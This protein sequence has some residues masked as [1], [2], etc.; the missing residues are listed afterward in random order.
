MK[1]TL[2]R[3]NSLQQRIRKILYFTILSGVVIY[4]YSLGRG[5][6]DYFLEAWPI[7]F[8]VMIISGFGILVQAVSFQEVQPPNTHRLP[9]VEL[10]RIWSFSGV[11]SVIA[12]IFAGLATRT[13]LLVRSGMTLSVCMTTT[14]RQIWMGLEYALLL[15][16]L[17]AVFIELQGA[18]YLAIGMVLAGVV[19]SLVRVYGR[20]KPLLFLKA[21]TVLGPLKDHFSARAHP[22]FVA[23]MLTMTATYL[24]AFNGLEAS[25]GFQEAML[26]SAITILASIIVLTPNGLGV[27]DAVWVFVSMKAGLGLEKSVAL[28]IIIRLAY[29]AAAMLAWVLLSM[30]ARVMSRTGE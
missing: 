10:A 1:Q 21:K 12:P 7:F 29:L 26:L 14:I 17:A 27:M 4:L 9:L 20:E 13:A 16:G 30:A 22:W 8:G 3:K 24:V 6:W 23:Q 2:I 19:M 5:P 11:V 15:G 28:A 18:G 25:I